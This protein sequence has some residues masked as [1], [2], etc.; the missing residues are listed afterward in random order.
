MNPLV[1]A[2]HAIVPLTK[3]EQS[4]IDDHCKSLSLQK[5]QALIQAG[6]I[7]QHIAWLSQGRLRVFYYADND[8]EITCYFGNPDQFIS[9]YSSYLTQTP[10]KE[11]IEAIEDCE[12]ITLFREDVETLSEAIPK[13]HIFRRIIAENLFLMMERRIAMLQSQSAQ[14]RYEALI[15][16]H[17]EWIL[18]IPL[19]YTASFLG[20]TPQHL[21]RL[22]KKSL[23]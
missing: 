22:R 23:S 8:Q 10:T 17:P 3:T 11:N 20:I 4:Q 14:E 1:S 12:L 18:N 2:I 7:C 21:S 16:N 5:G 6:Q 15:L 9:S 19:Q 13:I